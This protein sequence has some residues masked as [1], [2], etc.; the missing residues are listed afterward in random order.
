M[1]KKGHFAIGL[2]AVLALLLYMFT[3]YPVPTGY[4]GYALLLSLAL[5]I[6]WGARGKPYLHIILAI[7]ALVWL[8]LIH[9]L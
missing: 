7:V 5:G 3:A 1:W 4:I 2:A 8:V 9:I 6:G